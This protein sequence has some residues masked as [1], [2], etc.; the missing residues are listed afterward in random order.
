MLRECL[1]LVYFVYYRLV[2]VYRTGSRT[3]GILSKQCLLVHMNSDGVP[4]VTR[5][6]YGLLPNDST[7][8]YRLLLHIVHPQRITQSHDRRAL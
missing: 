6:T 7:F 8:T 4:V 2:D 5:Y 1:V 3:I